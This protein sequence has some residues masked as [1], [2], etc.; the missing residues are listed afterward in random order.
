MIEKAASY[1][2]A[3]LLNAWNP[4][5][6]ALR[7]ADIMGGVVNEEV[8]EMDEFAVDPE[9]CAGIGKILPF[10]EAGADSR[11]GDTL[12]ETGQ[13]DPGVE[14]RP[15]RNWSKSGGMRDSRFR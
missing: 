12:V 13:G 9:R 11:A 7:R 3:S 5:E 15:H 14:S 2:A 10:E 1:S 4:R 8:V 6:V